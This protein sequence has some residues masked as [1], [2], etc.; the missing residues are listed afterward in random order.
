MATITDKVSSVSTP[1]QALEVTSVTASAATARATTTLTVAFKMNSDASLKDKCDYVGVSLPSGWGP[2]LMNGA[3]SMGA[4]TL[5][6][7][8]ANGTALNP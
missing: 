5:T 1:T 6:G 3:A 4:A 2:V 7:A 8:L